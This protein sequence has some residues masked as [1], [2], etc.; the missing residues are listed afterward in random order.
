MSSLTSLIKTLSYRKSI[1]N[2]YL[3]VLASS[4]PGYIRPKLFQ[5]SRLESL[6]KG[7]VIFPERSARYRCNGHLHPVT[8]IVWVK[9]LRRL[10]R[11][12]RGKHSPWT[13]ICRSNHQGINVFNPDKHMAHGGV[14]S[15]SALPCKL[16]QKVPWPSLTFFL[17]FGKYSRSISDQTSPL[18]LRSSSVVAVL[19]RVHQ[20][21]PQIHLSEW[22]EPIARKMSVSDCVAAQ[23]ISLSFEP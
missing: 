19:G 13:V 1:G 21:Q 6:Y 12:L 9:Y 7:D 10:R 4:H 18:T 11:R 15:V 2:S 5:S 3:V 16:F 17:G 8:V 14:G 22:S 20:F 23:P